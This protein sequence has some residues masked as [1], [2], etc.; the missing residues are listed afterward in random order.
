M[1]N[2]T[3]IERAPAEVRSLHR[4]KCFIATNQMRKEVLKQKEE[5]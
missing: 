1:Q 5:V 4:R 3:E 2:F